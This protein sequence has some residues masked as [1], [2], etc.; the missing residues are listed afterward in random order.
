MSLARTDC[1]NVRLGNFVELSLNG[2]AVQWKAIE[3]LLTASSAGAALA[4]SDP[5][6]WD[7][8]SEEGRDERPDT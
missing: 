4:R 3:P 2:D 1:V 7:V 8:R 5:P 6:M